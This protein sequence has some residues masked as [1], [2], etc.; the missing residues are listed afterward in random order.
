METKR[1][2]TPEPGTY[3]LFAARYISRTEG[4]GEFEPIGEAQRRSHK[5]VAEDLKRSL[6][7]GW[8]PDPVELIDDGN[9]TYIY[10][11]TW[12]GATMYEYRKVGRA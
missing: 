2:S 1:T 4:F 8:N 5:P 6:A 11:K 12:G 3:Q 7:S 9:G 10:K